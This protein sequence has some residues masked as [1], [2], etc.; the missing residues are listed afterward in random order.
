[1]KVVDV[2]KL[3]E[4]LGAR[5]VRSDGEEVWASCPLGTHRDSDP[6]FHIRNELSGEHHGYWRCYG[7]H[8]KGGPI[9]LVRKVRGVGSREARK[10][11]ENLRVSFEDAPRKKGELEVDLRI[12]GFDPAPFVLPAG[13]VRAPLAR[14]P[15]PLRSYASSRGISAEQVDHWGLGYAVAGVLAM[16][17]VFPIADETGRLGSYSA[18]TAIG[19]RKRYLTPP[20][21]EK[22][23]PGAIFGRRY[24]PPLAE[25]A[26]GR[27]YRPGDCVLVE[28]AINGLAV[29]RVFPTVPFGA[30]GG[31]NDA[32]AQW[33]HF[34]LFERLVLLTDSDRAGDR[35]AEAYELSGGPP[36]IR[37]RLPGKLDAQDADPELLRAVLE[38]VFT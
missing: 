1:M 35:V 23:R 9:G 36:A 11:L 30:L 26:N 17:V 22:P 27:K 7:C 29:E 31:S 25:T 33:A 37:A 18:R 4:A 12:R 10:F 2:P 34:G 20:L 19:D 15:G 16:R 6:S 8:E 28:G 21:S 5:N 38:K 13:V 32:A 3:L 14:W 24:W